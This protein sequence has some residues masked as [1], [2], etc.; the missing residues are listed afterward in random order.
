MGEYDMRIIRMDSTVRNLGRPRMH[1]NELIEGWSSKEQYRSEVP[2]PVSNSSSF[3][4]LPHCPICLSGHSCQ[5]VRA[6]TKRMGTLIDDK[7]P[8][9]AQS[10]FD[11]LVEAG[12]KPSLVTYTTLLTALTNQKQFKS[13]PSL[14]SQVEQSGLKPDSIFF[15][16]IINAFSEAG[17]IDEA[18][19][20]FCKM[21]QSG[22]RPTTSTFNT[23]IKGYGIAGKPEESQKLLDMMSREAKARPNQKTYNILIKAWCDQKNFSEAWNVVYKMC[24]SGMRPDVVTYN[25]IARAYAENGETKRAE[26]MVLEMETELR[27]NERTLA[28]IVRGYCKEGKMENALRCVQRMKDLGVRPNVIVFNTLIKGFLDIE[29]MGGVDEVSHT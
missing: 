2:P 9:E 4:P 17:K 10:I 20:I 7:K 6:R 18:M 29:D 16:A 1:Q 27:P 19:K 15:N 28:I 21:A 26:D 8:H 14:I 22:C 3:Q 23:L 5:T 12:H 25:T 24:A 11:G 13:I